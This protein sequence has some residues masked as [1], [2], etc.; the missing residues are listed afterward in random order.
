VFNLYK[1]LTIKVLVVKF[2]K[3]NWHKNTTTKTLKTYNDM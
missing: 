2:V 3:D 1:K